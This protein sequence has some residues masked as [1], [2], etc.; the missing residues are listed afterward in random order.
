MKAIIPDPPPQPP[1][2]TTPP[3]DIFRGH[4]ALVRQ[5]QGISLLPESAAQGQ[6]GV[7]CRVIDGPQMNREMGLITRGAGTKPGSLGVRRVLWAAGLMS[8]R[9]EQVHCPYSS[10]V[11][12][13]RCPQFTNSPM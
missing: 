5:G 13:Q 4:P 10:C 11:G 6:A 12:G 1:Y 3:P 9:R 8:W 7:S 2:P